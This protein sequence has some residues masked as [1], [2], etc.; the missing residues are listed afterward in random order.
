MNIYGS[1]EIGADVCYVVLCQ[2]TFDAEDMLIGKDGQDG[3]DKIEESND[4]KKVSRGENDEKIKRMESPGTKIDNSNDRTNIITS[5]HVEEG[6]YVCDSSLTAQTF[7]SDANF[8]AG[9]NRFV[10]KSPIGYAIDGNELFVVRS[11]K[12]VK[13]MDSCE[14]L[15]DIKK[16]GGKAGEDRKEYIVKNECNELEEFELLPDGVPGELLVGGSQLAMGYHNRLHETNC[17]FISRSSIRGVDGSVRSTGQRVDADLRRVFR[18]GDI[19]V[20]VPLVPALSSS[21]SSSSFSSQ[22]HLP[23][24]AITSAQDSNI[25]SKGDNEVEDDKVKVKNRGRGSGINENGGATSYNDSSSDFCSK[26]PGSL[27]WL[28]RK[29]LQVASKQNI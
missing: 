9:T 19:V 16:T 25:P 29:D 27:V 17:R 7:Y 10:G 5:H 23:S 11:L 24:S 14:T 28:G 26:W 15:Y 21:S 8:Q 3:T 18:T 13:D 4:I 2:P 22:R 20:R 1:T 6:D 12:I